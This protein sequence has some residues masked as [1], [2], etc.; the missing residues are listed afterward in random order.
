MAK[1]ESQRKPHLRMCIVQNGYRLML[2]PKIVKM[3]VIIMSHT[4]N[5]ECELV[6]GTLHTVYRAAQHLRLL[7]P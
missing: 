2:L 4:T 7:N 1:R 5:L 3:T 6:I